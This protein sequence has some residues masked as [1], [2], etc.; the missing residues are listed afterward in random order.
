VPAIAQGLCVPFAPQVSTRCLLSQCT[1][2]S[3]AF[4][5]CFKAWAPGSG[6][7]LGNISLFSG[8]YN[9]LLATFT[10]TAGLGPGVFRLTTLSGS[11]LS[12]C[13][14]R[15]LTSLGFPSLTVKEICD[16]T[17]ATKSM[18]MIQVCSWPKLQQEGE[19][20]A[21][22][23]EVCYMRCF[24]GRVASFTKWQYAGVHSLSQAL[25]HSYLNIIVCYEVPY[26][27]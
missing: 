24:S 6:P 8:T 2:D 19:E 22:V 25:R 17:Q 5:I 10:S 1:T 15:G 21:K 14:R 7:V 13:S 9:G 11:E 16:A 23:K 3:S 18:F 4:Q 20:E 27:L 12:S 26:K